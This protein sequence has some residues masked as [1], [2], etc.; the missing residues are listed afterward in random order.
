MQHVHCTIPFVTH[1][2]NNSHKVKK[3]SRYVISNINLLNSLDCCFIVC[4]YNDS[5]TVTI[6]TGRDTNVI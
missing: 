6:E 3:Q 5:T 2:I 1:D 4:E